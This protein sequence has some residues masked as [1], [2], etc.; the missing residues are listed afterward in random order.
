MLAGAPIS[1][2][3]CEVPGWGRML[4]ARPRIRRDGIARADRDGARADRLPAVRAGG[5]PRA[6]RPPRPAARRR[7][8]A[9]RAAHRG[10]RPGAR[11]G[12]PDRARA[13]RCRRRRVRRRRGRRRRLVH[14]ASRSTTPAGPGS[15]ATSVRSSAWSQATGSRSR[16]TL[17]SARRSSSAADVERMLA[18][19]DAGWCLDTGHLLIGGTDPTDFVRRHGDRI[20]HAHLKDVDAGIAQRLRAGELTLV[21][22]T[23]AG[24]FRPLGRGD[25][26]DRRGRRSA[27]Q[28]GLRAL[29]RARA[30]HRD[31]R[32]GAAGGTWSGHRC[33]DEHRLPALAG[34]NAE[35]EG[36]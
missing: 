36:C 14:P 18:I 19:S 34:S 1:W 20:V 24:L 22:A 2:G 4:D 21:E 25:A 8:R 13:G 17:T 27:A 15:H 30:G 10:P 23:Q 7:L 29:A 16:C 26:T 12:R 35:R 33:A 3:V 11:V 32:G 5:D 6:A 28:V 31:H 9:A